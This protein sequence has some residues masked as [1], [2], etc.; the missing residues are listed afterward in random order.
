V[1]DFINDVGEK[2]VCGRRVSDEDRINTANQSK[3]IKGLI[4]IL[5]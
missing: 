5:L 3:G 1:Q 4:V 2:R